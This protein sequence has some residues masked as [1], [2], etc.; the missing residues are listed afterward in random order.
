MIALAFLRIKKR[1]VEEH[2]NN[3][4]I[5]ND[6]NENGIGY[7]SIPWLLVGRNIRLSL[8]IFKLHPCFLRIESFF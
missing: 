5:A 7:I 8:E 1:K 2:T 4:L 6:A 3:G